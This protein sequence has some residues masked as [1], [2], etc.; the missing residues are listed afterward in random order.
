MLVDGAKYQFEKKLPE[1]FHPAIH[2]ISKA[3]AVGGDKP[4][5]RPDVVKA[6]NKAVWAQAK[7]ELVLCPFSAVVLC[8]VSAVSKR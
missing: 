4:S 3:T 6:V 2:E 1:R 5:D 7:E 8:P